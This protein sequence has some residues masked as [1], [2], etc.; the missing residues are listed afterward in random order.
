MSN[1]T[2]RDQKPALLCA[3]FV[4]LFA[5]GSAHAADNVATDSSLTLEEVIVTAQKRDERLQDV[6]VP[7][8][9]LNADTLVDRNQLRIQDY[10]SSVPGLSFSTNSQGDAFIA[11][12]GITT[13]PGSG[14]PTVGITVDDVPYGSSSTYGGF[15]PPAPDIDPGELRSV[16]VLRGPQGALYGA[17]SIGGLLKFVTVDPS[18]DAFSGRVQTGLSDVHNGSQLGYNVRGGINVPLGDTVA[19]RASA[20]T[21]TDPGFIDNVVT[22][23]EDANKV[24]VSGGRL[25]ALWRPSE[26][27]SAKVS[28]LFQD[29]KGFGS[30]DVSIGPGFGDLQQDTQNGTGEYEK[31]VQTYTATLTAKLTSIELTSLTGYNI[32]S[33]TDSLDLGAPYALPEDVRSSKVSEEIRASMHIGTILDWLVGFFFTHEDSRVSQAL[34]ILGDDTGQPASVYGSARWPTTYTE[35][36]LFS[37]LTFHLTD[38]FDFQVGGR[39]SYNRQTYSE[40]DIGYGAAEP[41]IQPEVKTHDNSFTYLLTPTFKLS[42]DMMIYARFAS[43]YRPGGPNA[44]CTLLNVPCAFSPDKTQ[45]YDLGIKGDLLNRMISYDASLYYIDWKDIQLNTSRN[46]STFYANGSKARSQGLELSLIARPL[47]GTTINAQFSWSDAKLTEPLPPNSTVSGADGDRLPFSARITGGLTVQQDIVISDDLTAFAN[48]AENYL[49]PRVG[50]F[51]PLG[52]PGTVPV[53]QNY[54][55]YVTTDARAGLRFQ[56]WAVTAFLTN[57]T[58]KR[59]LLDGGLGAINP[60]V[61]DIIQPRTVGLSV[62]REF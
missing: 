21:R 7:V 26:M 4:V 9:V 30:Q 48:V 8:T 13:G 50:T 22:G 23:Q 45:N 3:P 52:D 62:A 56:H 53:R 35:Y 61:F 39:E 10:F 16:E 60:T 44:T 12:R 42:P 11:V 49:G 31:K 47:S 46:F 29:T 17:S 25:A 27:F 55:G 1:W 6:P 40:V 19:I 58:D 28:A 33:L 32:Y 15:N 5:S 54:G 41:A 38:R 24:R 59:G 43:G 37:D 51:Q 2:C 36:A 14:N 20:F 18:T 34:L 57:A